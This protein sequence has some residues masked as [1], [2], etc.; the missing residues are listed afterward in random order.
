MTL[1]LSL[2]RC[3][4]I[5][6][7]MSIA[8]TS[9]M[10]LVT[11]CRSLF[12]LAVKAEIRRPNVHYPYDWSST[13]TCTSAF[14]LRNFLINFIGLPEFGAKITPLSSIPESTLDDIHCLRDFEVQ[15]RR[16]FAEISRCI[17]AAQTW[18]TS[19]HIFKSSQPG[20][21][22][23]SRRF[24]KTLNEVNAYNICD[25]TAIYVSHSD[26]LTTYHI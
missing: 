12:P 14:R 16:D 22:S 5:W 4:N 25:A 10:T 23:T 3:L 7:F 17:A 8:D 11:K 1:I 20:L 13:T 6:Y 15:V 2:F 19:G 9:R 21:E 18:K 24:M 26:H